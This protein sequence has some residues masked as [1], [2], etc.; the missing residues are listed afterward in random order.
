[1]TFKEISKSTLAKVEIPLPPLS[2]Q[3]HIVSIL[4]EADELRRLRRDAID[5]SKQFIAALFDEMFGTPGADWENDNLSKVISSLAPGK[6]IKANN[7]P[8]REGKWGV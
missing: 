8:A 2:E 6:S 3:R 7:D 4:R 1:A 5:K